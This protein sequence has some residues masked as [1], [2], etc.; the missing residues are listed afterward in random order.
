M[1]KNSFYIVKFNKYRTPT[2]QAAEELMEID[3]IQK[4]S[5]IQKAANRKLIGIKPEDAEKNL[6]E[7]NMEV[8]NQLKDM[9][10]INFLRKIS[11]NFEAFNV[12][13]ISSF[14]K[15]MD[16]EIREVLIGNWFLFSF[17]FIYFIDIYYEL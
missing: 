8:M 9:E 2:S 13:S 1:N 7:I 10:M 11:D 12:I 15:Y 4:N 3:E 6:K 5:V 16:Y 17:Y 14:G